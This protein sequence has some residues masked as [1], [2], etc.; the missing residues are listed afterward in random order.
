MRFL[1]KSESMTSFKFVFSLVIAAMQ[2]AQ[3]HD[4]SWPQLSGGHQAPECTQALQLAKT[5]FRSKDFVLYGPPAIPEDFD[6]ALALWTDDIEISGGNAL[7]SD[8]L[9]FDKLPLG[10][11]GTIRSLYWQK[12]PYGG[13]R[14]AIRERDMGWHGDMYSLYAVKEDV[15][16]KDLLPDP[17]L[18]N[19]PSGRL[20]PLVSD[21]WRP[22]LV[23]LQK[24]NGQPWV[25][26]AGEPYVFLG[27]WRVY[28]AGP[29]GVTLR[30]TVRFRPS[31][32][33]AVMLLPAPVRRLAELLD[34]TI[35]PGTNEGTMH[36][37]ARLRN[38]VSETWA[39]V[40]LRPWA[41]LVPYNSRREVD[42]G[43]I[44]WSHGG[45]SYARVYRAIEQQYPAAEQALASYYRTALHLPAA[46]ANS[47]ATSE[48]DAAFRS[49][50][51]LPRE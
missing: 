16:S 20:V 11:E 24:R 31:A 8:P 35:G 4:T 14:L 28:A 5:A 23:L 43:L 32:K 30:C 25:I 3:A 46:N 15:E 2:P 22:P 36:P 40:A 9:V 49:N 21:N 37:T 13:M 17:D 50:F 48:L 51:V 7:K 18:P 1:H 41:T 33:R 12:Q 26:D 42:A 27:D 10:N 44:A 45:A 38:D 29:G 34:Q 47:L 39:N 19:S 6:S